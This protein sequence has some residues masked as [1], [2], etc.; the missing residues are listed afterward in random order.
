M[1]NENN[2]S[3]KNKRFE[4]GY[5][6]ELA[7][8]TDEY[9]LNSIT[10]ENKLFDR[11][12]IKSMVS[13][14]KRR[15]EYEGY[16]LDLS[17]ITKNIIAMGFPASSLESIYR[18]DMTDVK[19]FFEKRHQNKCKVYN[20]CREKTY[21]EGT[22]NKQSYYP[23]LDHEAP[24]LDLLMP[25]CKDVDEW[26]KSDPENV[27]AIHCK[28]GKGRTGTFICCYLIYS[29][30]VQTAEDALKYYGIMRTENGKG[31]TIP[32]Q[33]RYVYYFEHIQKASIRDVSFAP[34]CK[35]TKIK[36]NIAPLK[37]CTLYF[38][39]RNNNIEYNYKDNHKIQSY[40]NPQSS[41][42][43]VVGDLLVSGDVKLEFYSKKTLGKDKLFTV[44]FNTMFI[45]TDGIL[46][47]KKSMLDKAHKDKENK[48]F[49]PKFKI[50]IHFIFLDDNQNEYDF[51]DL[52]IDLK[53]FELTDK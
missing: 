15:F 47:I 6:E 10:H 29:G 25:F 20:L 49:D 33:I 18:N 4:I 21:P 40:K 50:E 39:S 31:V 12:I 14:K 38:K 37:Q 16:N 13:K 42:E 22:F 53:N 1:E 17:Y 51:S 41:I 11:N 52:K 26:L 34:S 46:T 5:L 2:S 48:I 8:K 27:A 36:F 9:L 24:P 7:R 44:F 45:P 43:L 35:M 3:P 28:A 23:Y 30:L 32:S 19:R